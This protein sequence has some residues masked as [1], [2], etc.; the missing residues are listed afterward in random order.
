MTFY[1][2]FILSC[3]KKHQ[4]MRSSTLYHLLKGKRTS[5]ILSY[6]YFYGCL[7]YFSL[8]PKLVEVSY[9]KVLSDCVSAGF[10][11]EGEKGYY[12]LTEAGAKEVRKSEIPDLSE[13]K[14]LNYYKW[15][16]SF[17]DRLMFTSQVV[18]EKSHHNRAYVPVEGNL[19][20]QQRLKLWL[21]NQDNTL[22]YA[23]YK[24]WERIVDEMPKESHKMILGQLTGYNHRGYT[25]SQLAKKEQFDT[26][27]Y[28]LSFK[29]NLHQFITIIRDNHSNFPLFYSLLEDEIALTKEDSCLKSAKLFSEGFSLEEIAQMRHLKV[30]TVTDHLIEDYI[31]NPSES[32]L[33]TYSEEKEQVL[34]LF[35]QEQPNFYRWVFKEALSYAPSLTFY[36]FKFYQFRL[37]EEGKSHV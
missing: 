17:F 37:V 28:Y 21:K 1:H 34:A 10:L 5:S 2:L 13:L 35:Y 15:D 22:E 30:S 18:S 3:F 29:H 19:F 9:Q 7:P 33:K 14:Q 8:F 31:I 26:I 23:F 4:E 24:E 6:G 16:I 36:E 25:L 27:H 11:K 20:K 12:V 32:K